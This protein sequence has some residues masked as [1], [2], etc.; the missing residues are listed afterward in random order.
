HAA[1]EL[2]LCHSSHLRF[3]SLKY[4]SPVP[5]ILCRALRRGLYYTT[6]RGAE[7]VFP[8]F[9]LG[10]SHCGKVVPNSNPHGIWLPEIKHFPRLMFLRH[11]PGGGRLTPGLDQP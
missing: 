9:L 5:R 11:L 3:S 2:S 1:H 4:E 7:S 10:F 6:T 8:A